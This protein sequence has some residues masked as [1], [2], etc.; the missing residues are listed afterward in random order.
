MCPVSDESALFD[1]RRLQNL[2]DQGRYLPAVPHR[3][4]ASVCSKDLLLNSLERGGEGGER[5]E[6]EGERGKDG[7]KERVEEGRKDGGGE[8]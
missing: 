7:G 5:E 2:N 1:Q 8:G 4:T 3:S 6:R